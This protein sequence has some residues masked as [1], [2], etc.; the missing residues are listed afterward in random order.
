[1]AR[2]QLENTPEVTE[3]KVVHDEEAR[4]SN[5]MV[6][7]KLWA[8]I[9]DETLISMTQ[10]SVAKIQKWAQNVIQALAMAVTQG[11]DLWDPELDLKKYDFMMRCFP[12]D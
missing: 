6:D 9:S 4:I 2:K 5:I 3:I 1:M 8:S 12:W 11:V 7:G 10:T